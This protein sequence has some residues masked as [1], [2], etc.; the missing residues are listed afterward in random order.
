MQEFKGFWDVIVE[1]DGGEEGRTI[2]AMAEPSMRMP[3]M[4][5][6]KCYEMWRPLC[7]TNGSME[8]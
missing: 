4:L 3:M 1:V 5:R 7:G 6:I 8:E 2:G